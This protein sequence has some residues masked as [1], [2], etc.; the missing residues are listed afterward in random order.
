[1]TAD[2]KEYLEACIC[3]SITLYLWHL[4]AAKECPSPNVSFKYLPTLLM[5]PTLDCSSGCYSAGSLM[6]YLVV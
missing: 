2:W 4:I 5:A 6:E 1:M 3:R